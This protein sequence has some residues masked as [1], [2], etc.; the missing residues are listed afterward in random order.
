MTGALNNRANDKLHRDFVREACRQS[1]ADF[2]R[3]WLLKDT[4]WRKDRFHQIVVVFPDEVSSI[5]NPAPAEAHQAPSIT[6][7]G[8]SRQ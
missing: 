3:T 7:D 4:S 6:F 2:V 1:V 8:Q 5:S